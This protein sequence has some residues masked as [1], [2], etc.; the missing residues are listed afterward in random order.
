MFTSCVRFSDLQI[1]FGAATY[2]KKKQNS[3][4]PPP[5]RTFV[6]LKCIQ[7]W[8]GFLY[9]VIRLK[10]FSIPNKW[11][12]SIRFFPS[13]RGLLRVMRTRHCRNNKLCHFFFFVAT[14][15]RSDDRWTKSRVCRNRDERFR[16]S[17][18][19]QRVILFYYS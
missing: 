17:S 18:V 8:L 3:T 15:W 10:T 9:Y 2:E 19:R 11:V 1:L 13:I 16:N 6:R 7:L 14:R 4:S 5:N 12:L